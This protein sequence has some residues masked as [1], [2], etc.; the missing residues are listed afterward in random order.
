MDT[1]CFIS[2]VKIVESKYLTD[3]LQMNPSNKIIIL[4]A[5]QAIIRRQFKMKTSTF[6]FL[7]I[8]LPLL[9]GKANLMKE[10]NFNPLLVTA[11]LRK[12]VNLEKDTVEI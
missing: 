10:F 11:V 8:L 1:K 6:L 7:T 3:L 9:P 12:L 4:F 2:Y 5:F